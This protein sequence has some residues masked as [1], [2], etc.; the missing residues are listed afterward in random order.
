MNI[1]NLK[2]LKKNLLRDNMTRYKVALTNIG[3]IA[4]RD[5]RK[6]GTST[7]FKKKILR[8]AKKRWRSC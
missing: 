8:V 6:R 5:I 4:T 3:E 1:K 2:D 7:R